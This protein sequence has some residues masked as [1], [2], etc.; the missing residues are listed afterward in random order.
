MSRADL[1]M[2]PNSATGE[3]VRC[4][5]RVRPVGDDDRSAE[6]LCVQVRGN[7]IVVDAAQA[8]ARGEGIATP[9]R[10]AT[11]AGVP[12]RLTPAARGAPL[13]VPQSRR[14]SGPQQAQTST[15]RGYAF[16]DVMDG[17]ASQADV[18]RVCEP[19][20]DAVLDGFNACIFAYG[21][22]GSGKTHTMLGTE[23]EPGVIR[24]ACHRLFAALGE[25]P[26]TEFHVSCS[27]VELYNDEFRDLLA[28]EHQPGAK[29]ALPCEVEA[30]RNK[31]G[32]SLHQL[33]S[34][35]GEPPSFCL[36][37]SDTLR[38]P[39]MCAR[40]LL[41][42]V[43]YGTLARAVGQTNLNAH[44]SRSHAVLTVHVESCSAG[45]NRAR[46][47]KLHLVDLAGSENLTLSGAEGAT[48]V[49][50]Q[51]INSSLTALCDVLESLSRGAE[52]GTPRR[53]PGPGGKAPAV[54][55][56]RN[57]KLT[58]LLSD[59]IGGN[60]KTLMITTVLP[61]A[62]CHRQTLMAVHFAA[63]ASAIRARAPAAVNEDDDQSGALAT[64]KREIDTLRA[65]LAQRDQEMDMIEKV[66]AA[67]SS[68]ETDVL[69]RRLEDLEATRL[70]E[71]ARLKAQ[72]SEVIHL[73][74][75]EQVEGDYSRSRLELQLA[76]KVD[77]IFA[78]RREVLEQL[79][80]VERLQVLR[81]VAWWGV[82]R[83]PR[84]PSHPPRA[85]RTCSGTAAMPVGRQKRPA[86]LPSPRATRTR[87]FSRPCSP[88]G[89]CV[90]AGG[91]RRAH[92]THGA[93]CAR[94]RRT[95]GLSPR[96]GYAR[97]RWKL[98]SSKRLVSRRRATRTWQTPRS[99]SQPSATSWRLP[100][101]LRRPRTRTLPRPVAPSPLSRR[102]APRRRRAPQ[103]RGRPPPTPP[104]RSPP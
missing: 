43:E 100:N 65:K 42:F 7:E 21:Q 96:P 9:S 69:S 58:R 12:T 4:L 30:R 83:V 22:T 27:F 62:S 72:M 90:R 10:P 32:L 38:S 46:V 5:I 67:R 92:P 54:V 104:L 33:P 19:F 50:A 85:H 70:A 15:E 16:D 66:S 28:P 81:V 57:H 79:E 78:L 75:A 11:G 55:P 13:S 95:P 3:R 49:E 26:D 31:P 18:W 73:R 103:K 20:V 68:A 37:G 88:G 44:S 29:R 71:E 6:E 63:R 25:R 45:S 41:D 47:G 56:Y 64:L 94:R 98:V 8:R 74:Q 14:F 52:P 35:R 99:S 102:R 36:A 53:V 2:A 84:W 59:A 61:F 17:S 82:G 60:S 89:R 93:R 39:A 34:R 23:M 24:R 51:A 86:T 91:D 1:K 76:H 48:R 80:V 87:P 101:A 97:R 77:A 40:D